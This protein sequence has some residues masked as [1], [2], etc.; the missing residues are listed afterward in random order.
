MVES[1]S[2]QDEANAAFWLATRAGKMGL[3][4][5]LGI[6]RVGPARKV[7]FLAI[8]KSFIDQAC[9]VKMAVLA[10]FFLAFS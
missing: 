1:M 10:S 9:L 7:L 4:C 5:R 6:S 3:F 8:N 2:R